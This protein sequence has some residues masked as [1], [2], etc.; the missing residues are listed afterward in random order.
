MEKYITPANH[1]SLADVQEQID[2][3]IQISEAAESLISSGLMKGIFDITLKMP[4]DLIFLLVFNI[5]ISIVAFLF[6]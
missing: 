1:D 6:E 4:E 3:F 5:S 2:R